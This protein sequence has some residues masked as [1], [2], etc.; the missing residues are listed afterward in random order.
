MIAGRN[1]R[2]FFSYISF[3]ILVSCSKTN[4]NSPAPILNA[5]TFTFT[6]TSGIDHFFA[7]TIVLN[8]DASKRYTYFNGRW[9]VP[10]VP[11]VYI[12]RPDPDSSL[13]FK[14]HF[15]IG[16]SPAT[17]F[18]SLPHFQT[19]FSGTNNIS[20]VPLF[21][22][23]YPSSYDVEP[24]DPYGRVFPGQVYL[25]GFTINTS[26]SDSTGGF[27]SGSFN[28]SASTVGSGKIK[29]VGKFSNSPTSYP[30]Y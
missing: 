2:F 10:F 19:S 17:L 25:A 26:I 16:Q 13:P 11:V 22:H 8:Q 7:D 24:P 30:P 5:F 4:H 18:F 9:D 15:N 21:L 27:L 6:D 20:P 23:W 1:I 29:I 14:F 3:V 12:E 28:I